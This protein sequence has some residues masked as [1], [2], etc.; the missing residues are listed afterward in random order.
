MS[1]PLKHLPSPK[2]QLSS[3]QI[4]FGSILAISLLLA[5]NFSGRI[6]AGQRIDG[7]LHALEST[8][9]AEQITATA[10]KAELNYVSHDAYVEQWARQEGKMLKPGE[11]LIKPVPGKQPTPLV[12]TPFLITVN[13]QPH[14]DTQNWQLWWELFFDSPPPNNNST[15]P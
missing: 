12:P 7:E 3:L 13:N 14:P 10:L 1:T 2:N 11:L 6:A 5:I 9:N 4:V 15:N 8:I